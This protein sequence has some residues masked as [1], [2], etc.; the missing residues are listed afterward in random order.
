MAPLN[1]LPAVPLQQPFSGSFTYPAEDFIALAEANMKPHPTFFNADD[2]RRIIYC[3]NAFTGRARLWYHDW[4]RRKV[5][6]HRRP[7]DWYT[8]FKEDFL[9]QFTIPKIRTHGWLLRQLV[10]ETSVHAYAD[11][12]RKTA[13]ACGE[14]VDSQ[15]NR[16]WWV[17]GLR[18]PLQSKIID[19]FPL[20][21]TFDELVDAAADHERFLLT[22]GDVP[23]SGHGHAGNPVLP[24]YL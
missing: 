22:G 14:N 24:A 11:V 23:R 2:R 12:Y 6:D 9:E 18:G 17:Y 15:H 4:V 1:L 5:H 16:L 7:A 19:V 10:L 21:D 3:V 20:L 8:V 13:A